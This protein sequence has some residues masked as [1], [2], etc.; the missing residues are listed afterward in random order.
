MKGIGKKGA[1]VPEVQRCHRS[2][3]DGERWHRSQAHQRP[4][5]PRS[6]C[7]CASTGGDWTCGDVMQSAGSRIWEMVQRETEVMM[8]HRY[9]HP[10]TVVDAEEGPTGQPLRAFGWRGT[11]YRVVEVLSQW[12]LRDRW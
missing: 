12:H 9:G 10:I 7:H 3:D 1:D 6:G 11:I 2:S 5:G 4:Q 8:A